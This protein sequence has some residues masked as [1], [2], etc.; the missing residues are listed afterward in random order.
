MPLKSN[1]DRPIRWNLLHR[2]QLIEIIALWEGRV[3]TKTLASAYMALAGNWLH[4]ALM[5]IT[6]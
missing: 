5:L 6:P 2:Y 4:R 3:T 1:I